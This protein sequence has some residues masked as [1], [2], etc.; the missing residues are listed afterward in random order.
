[1]KKQKKVE[2][3]LFMQGRKFEQEQLY[4]EAAK[5]YEKILK[6]NPVHVDANNRLMIVYR[7]LKQ[8]RKES[9]L[10]SKAIAAHEKEIEA[11]QQQWI[12]EHSKMA[13]LSRPLAQSLGL[14]NTKGL[15]VHENELLDKWKRRKEVVV[16]K[17]K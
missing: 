11:K 8:Y 4:A 12:K 2:S 17:I 1:M 14:L 5:Q 16:K 10:I 13:E 9:V 15:P 7:K 6:G 3:G